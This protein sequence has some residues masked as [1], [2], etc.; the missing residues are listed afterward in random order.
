M[1][2]GIFHFEIV[3]Q[4]DGR[5]EISLPANRP[6]TIGRDNACDV[7]LFAIHASRKHTVVERTSD[8][9]RVTDTSLNGTLANGVVLRRASHVF[10]EPKVALLVGYLH[11]QISFEETQGGVPASTARREAPHQSEVRRASTV[12]PPDSPDSEPK[13]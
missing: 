3:G 10:T 2:P 1:K 8:G 7:P 12:P 6:L 9:I 13:E 11:I 5:H 4:V